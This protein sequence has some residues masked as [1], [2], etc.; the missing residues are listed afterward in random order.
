M[1]FS[2]IFSR[3]EKILCFAFGFPLFS[4]REKEEL[5]TQSGD[6]RRRKSVVGQRKMRFPQ[7]PQ[8]LILLLLNHSFILSF[9]RSIEGVVYAGGDEVKLIF[10]VFAT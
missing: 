3:F 2:V 5:S 4:H 9:F 1:N 6:R 10:H 8:G 7:Y